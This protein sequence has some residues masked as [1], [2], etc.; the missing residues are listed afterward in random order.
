ML[1]STRA[2][3]VES[4][5]T[6]RRVRGR[7]LYHRPHHPRWSAGCLLSR[8]LALLAF[9][10]PLDR[11][12]VESAAARGDSEGLDAVPLGVAP[13][14]ANSRAWVLQLLEAG[15]RLVKVVSGMTLRRKISRPNTSRAF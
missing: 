6:I 4:A 8:A 1:S 11:P 2:R 13:C 9:S 5:L 14:P 7:K 3:Q 12:S 15:L 10:I